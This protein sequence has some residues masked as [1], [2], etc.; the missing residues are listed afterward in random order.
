MRDFFKV[1]KK[2]NYAMTGYYQSNPNI[3]LA[4][5]SKNTI[6]FAATG[7]S[8]KSLLEIDGADITVVTKDCYKIN[9]QGT[10]IFLS[11]EGKKRG[12]FTAG[13]PGLGVISHATKV[14]VEGLMKRLSQ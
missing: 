10:E 2:N 7:I 5:G 8:Y 3:C 1:L 11:P 13:I 6:F 4:K 14:W 9:H 12:E